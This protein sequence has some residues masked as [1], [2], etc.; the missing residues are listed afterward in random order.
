MKLVR[1][2]IVGIS[3]IALLV[4]TFVSATY[5]WFEI[6]SRASVENFRF[7]VHGGPGFLVSIDNVNYYNDLSLVQMEKA[8]LTSFDASKYVLADDGSE[9]LSTVVQ[10]EKKILTDTEIHE[11]VNT[12]LKLLPATTNDGRT[13]RDQYGGTINVTSGDFVQ[14]SVYFKTTSDI[15]ADDTAYSIYLSGETQTNDKGEAVEPTMI[16]DVTPA[17][18]NDKYVRLSADMNL[19]QAEK[20]IDD[21]IVKKVKSKT[22]SNGDSVLVYS[23]NA[24]R[25][26]ITESVPE[27]YDIVDENNNPVIDEETGETKKGIRYVV[28][29]NST[30]LYELNDT[31]NLN[32]DL[33]S[34]ATDY[35]GGKSAEELNQM[36]TPKGT[37]LEDENLALYCSRFN[38]MYTYYNN[39]KADAPITHISY[40]SKP[41]T[42]RDLSNKDVI[43]TIKSGE[44][45][46]LLTFRLWLEGWDADCFD[47]LKYG[48]RVKL[49]FGSHK[50]D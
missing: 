14:F 7:Q 47:G 30:L 27:K 32:T 17:E 21:S 10:G 11:L 24:V 18:L 8:M 43:T 19:V 45:S 9:E 35:T 39:L 34:Y 36:I 15:K 48:V 2:L 50:S 42:I 38:A 37:I 26:S 44:G 41:N 13:F 12:N 25:L 1:K 40:Q 5:A 29:P 49:A 6:N 20:L 3:T 33:G 4:M 16:T 23:A 31:I 28:N 46:K 22:R